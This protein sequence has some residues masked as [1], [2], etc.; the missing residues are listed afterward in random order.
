[1]AK[2]QSTSAV[3]TSPTVKN[4][5]KPFYK[6]SPIDVHALLASLTPEQLA[7]CVEVGCY[8]WPPK[9]VR[10]VM[11]NLGPKQ[12]ALCELLASSGDEDLEHIQQKLKLESFEEVER[13][14]AD[15]RSQ[16]REM[17][18]HPQEV[19]HVD[20]RVYDESKGIE[21]HYYGNGEFI[22][23]FHKAMY[24]KK[25]A[26]AR[27]REKAREKKEEKEMAEIR[28]SEPQQASVS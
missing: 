22:E 2:A 27:R 8:C 9:M 1:M 26:D 24:P 10:D 6:P 11:A 7:E 28:A 15:L 23:N 3:L 12:Q 17:G 25:W 16:L 18:I 14:I 20:F 21:R 19:Y 4:S 5:S 13:V